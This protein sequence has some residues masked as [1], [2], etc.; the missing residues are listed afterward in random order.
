MRIAFLLQ[1]VGS[2]YGAERATLDLVEGL[3]SAGVD[4]RMLLIE[5]KRLALRESSLQREIEQR[6]IPVGVIPCRSAFSPALV[7]GIRSYLDRERVDVLHTVGYK[8]DLH[9]CLAACRV[10]RV[11]TV[12]TVHGWLFRP[13]LKERF[14]GWLDVRALRKMDA[15]VALSRYY[16][17][18]LCRKGVRKEMLCLIPSGLD[19]ETRNLKPETGGPTSP[20]QPGAYTFSFGMLGRFS[21]EK[22]ISMFIRALALA[23]ARG[24]ECRAVIAGDGPLRETI[25]SE[26][27]SA[28]LKDVVLM[29][30]YM[31]RDGFFG[32]VDLLVTCSKIENLPYG[33]LEAM[34]RGKPVIATRVGGLPDLIEQGRTGYLVEPED[35]KS[36][37]DRMEDVARD[38]GSAARLGLAGRERIE[39]EFALDR[40]V[41]RHVELYRTL[42]NEA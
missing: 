18:L 7:R 24:V 30:G 40:M 35:A 25:E 3:R 37:A 36:L 41:S 4:A 27:N 10:E 16:H 13:D 28:G 9:G 11:R 6:Q 42:V 19:P 21:S 8:A 39:R 29:A 5:E 33:V 15:V 14:Y 22:N 12:A 31:D 26:I 34:A 32:E 23:R 2:I 17:D 1:D 38:P 20:S